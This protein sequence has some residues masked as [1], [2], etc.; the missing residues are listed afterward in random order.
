[1]RRLV[2]IFLAASLASLLLAPSPATAA[3][4][5]KNLDVTFTA[6]NGSPVTQAGSHPFAMTTSFD[7]NT[8]IDPKLGEIP[9]EEFK[10]LVVDQPAGLAFDPRAVPRCSAADFL[11]ANGE[12][13]SSLCPDAT[14]IGIIGARGE[15]GNPN[16]SDFG[17][18]YN[19][20]PPPGAAAKFGFHVL[21]VAVTISGGVR[22]EGE[23]NLFA[24]LMNV[25][26]AVSFYG[27]VLTLWGNP[28]D[29]AHDGERGDC[30]LEGGS[31]PAGVPER[32]FIT[33]PRSCTGPLTTIFKAASWQN[34]STWVQSSASTHDNL[35]P[36][37]PLGMSGCA[38]LGFGPLISAKPT[39][40]W[41]E[42][43]SGLDVSVDVNDPGVTSPKGIAQSDIKKAVLTLPEGVTANP[44]L[45]EGL[46]V[47]TPTD[48][49]KERANSEPGEG[50]PESSKIGT[51]EVETPL[52]EDET[53]K[54]SLF[55][56]QPDD[57]T[58]A[59]P[60]T[61]NPF[62][63]LIA[64]YVVIKDSD[65]GILVKQAGKVEPD[66]QTGQ[67]VTTFD[68]LPQFPLGHVRFH[69]REGGRSP[70][71]TP[72]RCG[73]FT[74]SA[75]FT[76]WANPTHPLVTTTSFEINAGVGG[77][78]CPPGGVP[79]FHPSFTAGTIN[80]SAASYSPFYMRLTRK[81]GEQDMTKLSSILPPG[82]VGKLA[83]VSKCPD[84]EIA[85]A[86]GKTGRQE[87]IAP[88]CPANSKIGRIV[89]AAGVGPELTYVP[90]SLYLAG[91]YRGDPLS[92][93]AVVPAVAGPFDAGTVVVRL[94]LTL[95]PETAEV[96]VDGSASDPIPHILKGIV[97]KVRELEVYADRSE[98]TLNP[99][100]CRPSKVRA[101]LFGSFLD[102]FSP[103]DDFP[104][105][106]ADRFQAA[107]CA[108]LDF[109]P[110]LSL[111][112]K[113]GTR[114]GDH[115]TLRAV[116]IPHAGDA[117]FRR[118][119]VT[120]PRS[121][122]LDQAHIRTIC[123]R[124]Q[125][126]ARACPKGSVYGFAK[127]ITPLLDQPLQGPVYLRSSNHSLPDLVAALHGIVDID[128]VG[129][130]DSHKGGIRSSF[131][132][133]PD[134]PVS[135]FTLRMRGGTKGLIV[136]S[137]NLCVRPSRAIVRLTGQNRKLHNF[138]PLVRASDCG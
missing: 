98:F 50:C 12:H 19:L 7:V 44:S 24:S 124:V 112:L 36:P 58:T 65:L 126:A 109:K 61:E 103:A 49:S 57:P 16:P 87:L 114:R 56:A 73:D 52:L 88:S 68:D 101:T 4:G 137:R 96:E 94:A 43:P 59:A 5:I 91:R 125:F 22:S 105:S 42:S 39:T 34:P 130:I 47:C 72:P 6:S 81:D 46:G 60:E 13:P 1:M 62:D 28:A 15:A 115:P 76:P 80:N 37:N 3:F 66:P 10:D 123:T 99:T 71:V 14:A 82:L 92:V 75:E 129:R 120:L 54:G 116:V 35:V 48:L 27:S 136:N 67:L 110:K 74:A 83:G 119:V 77:S 9:D 79:P 30:F 108:G 32:P 127:A 90:G 118:A 100:G 85:A 2:L 135:K 95:N 17:I 93:V 29:P 11:F 41:A 78:S 111:R 117:N 138:H 89:S 107:G 55:I 18:V 53:L 31:C 134:A 132:N 131:E 69:L 33:M 20:V 70:L 21:G 122:F 23:R 38:K 25:S 113:G 8:K 128:V 86:S 102:I 104:I 26:Q 63:S 51:V 45:A 133:I 106:L 64:L 97:L 40:D 121:A 84:A